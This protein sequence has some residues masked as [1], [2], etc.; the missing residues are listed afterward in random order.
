MRQIHM[1]HTAISMFAEHTPEPNPTSALYK[2][3]LGSEPLSVEMVEAVIGRVIPNT[4]YRLVTDW[5]GQ[6]FILAFKPTLD[7][8]V[9]AW[10]RRIQV[11]DRVA[12]T[13]ADKIPEG[14]L[15]LSGE[16]LEALLGDT[17]RHG[18]IIDS[19]TCLVLTGKGNTPP[20]KGS[21]FLSPC[22]EWIFQIKRG[23][24]RKI[25]PVLYEFEV[26]A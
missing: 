25:R 16:E 14:E 2:L 20:S 17:L 9:L 7:A 5:D 4:T 19:R 24:V 18:E 12:E 1:T 10:T 6:H 26:A 3:A 23:L 11:T 13:L 15:P 22:G 21:L 8:P